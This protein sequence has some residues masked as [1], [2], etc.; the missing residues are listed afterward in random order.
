MIKLVELEHANDRD[1]HDDGGKHGG[2]PW[3]F[4]LAKRSRLGRLQ[5]VFFL[6]AGSASIGTASLTTLV[7]IPGQD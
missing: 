1:C 4:L 6:Q 7:R 5:V 3:G 2:G